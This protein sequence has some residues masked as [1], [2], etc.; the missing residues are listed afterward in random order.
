[1]SAFCFSPEIIDLHLFQLWLRGLSVSQV[2]SVREDADP[3]LRD[4]IELDTADHF[5]LFDELQ[6]SLEEPRSTLCLLDLAP[7]VRITL[8][9]AFYSFDDVVVREFLSRKFATRVRKDLDDVSETTGVPRRS[10]LR[11]F[12]NLKRYVK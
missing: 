8:A 4:V 12:D 3:M 9:D 10:C 11:Q 2:A 6:P 7:N 1:M 5:R